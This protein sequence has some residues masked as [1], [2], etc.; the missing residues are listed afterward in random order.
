MPRLQHRHWWWILAGLAF[1][2]VAAYFVNFGPQSNGFSQSTEDWGRFGEYVGGMF[3]IL[4]FIGVLFT[5]DLQRK[6]IEQLTRQGTVDELLRIAR[7][8]AAN[9]D[10]ALG[11]SIVLDN[12]SARA[13]RERGWE[14]A[15]VKN[16]LELAADVPVPKKGAEHDTM[17]IAKYHSSIKLPMDLAAPELDL[18]A[19]CVQDAFLFGGDSVAVIMAYYR[20]RYGEIVRRLQVFGYELKSTEFWVKNVKGPKAS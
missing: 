15:S 9:I 5:I 7:E 13:M 8:V 12:V 17:F 4:A 16:M 1:L 14:P 18:L 6:Q 19:N 2:V 3:G 20:D 11:R 10:L